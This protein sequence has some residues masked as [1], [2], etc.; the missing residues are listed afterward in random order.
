MFLHKSITVIAVLPLTLKERS[1]RNSFLV[2]LCCMVGL[3]FGTSTSGEELGIAWSNRIVPQSGRNVLAM[4][5][6]NSH[7]KALEFSYGRQLETP[8]AA[9]LDF[10]EIGQV[11][12]REI[13]A[14]ASEDCSVRSVVGL[15]S[16]KQKMV[17]LV[18]TD[19]GYALVLTSKSGQTSVVQLGELAGYDFYSI[20][21]LEDSVLLV[22]TSQRKPALVAL[23][24]QGKVLWK[25]TVAIRE[26]KKV[27]EEGFIALGMFCD[28]IVSPAYDN[29]VLLGHNGN[30][31]KMMLGESDVH[32]C[33]FDLTAKRI[34]KEIVVPGRWPS[35]TGSFE[36]GSIVFV[37]DT[38]ASMDSNFVVRKISVEFDV[39]WEQPLNIPGKW[40]S[41]AVIAAMGRDSVVVAAADGV[42]N[43]HVRRIDKN[44]QIAASFKHKLGT[45]LGI[46]K[47]T[48]CGEQAFINVAFTEAEGRAGQ[49]IVCVSSS[50]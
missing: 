37:S 21:R 16:L 42:S 29:V 13:A 6:A 27:K 17:G 33:R 28:A 2:S 45:T 43:L 30:F 20:A 32:I 47:I 41:P 5:C 50:E 1:M 34:S 36:D 26:A 4:Y 10:D 49:H 22:G 3:G 19:L 39:M 9:L 44:G 25:K 38:N 40:G 46:P 31:N 23:E 35:G 7:P 8:N 18:K 15:T 11:A 14:E 12:R 48:A 24:L